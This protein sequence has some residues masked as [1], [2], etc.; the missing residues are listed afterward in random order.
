[1]FFAK[2]KYLRA[3]YSH[4]LRRRRHRQQPHIRKHFSS[5][6]FQI[7]ATHKQY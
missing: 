1:M 4:C 5:S 3:Y 2:M 7:E 6:Y